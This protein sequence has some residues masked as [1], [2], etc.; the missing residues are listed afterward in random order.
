MKKILLTLACLCLIF[1]FLQAQRQI[2][3]N[4]HEESRIKIALNF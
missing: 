2:I 1:P 3:G 4:I